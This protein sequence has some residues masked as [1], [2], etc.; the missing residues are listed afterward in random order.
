LKKAC[1]GFHNTGLKPPALFFGILDFEVFYVSS[2]KS[3]AECV[4]VKVDVF[5]P[6]IVNGAEKVGP[7][8]ASFWAAESL[9]LPDVRQEIFEIGG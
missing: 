2:A 1:G 9:K 6:F 7:D 4:D 5:L 3:T 8:S